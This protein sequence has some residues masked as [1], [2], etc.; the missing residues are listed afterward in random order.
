[1]AVITVDKAIL[2]IVVTAIIIILAYIFRFGYGFR[3]KKGSTDPARN[4]QNP[5]DPN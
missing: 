5:S 2:I 4:L 1:M 3:N